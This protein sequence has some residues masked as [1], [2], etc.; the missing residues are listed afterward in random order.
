MP[1]F[2]LDLDSTVNDSQRQNYSRQ[3]VIDEI[4][5]GS[6]QQPVNIEKVE[7]AP[8]PKVLIPEGAL[9]TK[10]EE[11]KAEPKPEIKQDLPK[12][13]NLPSK[14]HSSTISPINHQYSGKAPT[15]D[16]FIPCTDITIVDLIIDESVVK[17]HTSKT[18]TA[19]AKED[20][21]T[22][23]AKTVNYRTALLPSGT[24]FRAINQSRIADTLV[25]GQTVVFTS[26][27][28]LFT[29]YF[30]IP[31][32]T[33]FTARVAD[34]HKPQMTCNGGL[35]GLKIVSANINGYN[36]QLDGSILRLKND[37]IY[38]SNLK[39]EHTYFK[40]VRKKAK[41]G[42]NKFKQWSKTSHQLANK[43][44]GVVL[45]PF[46]YIGGCVL[47]AASTVSSPATA[48]LGKGGNLVIPPKTTFTIKLNSDARLR[49]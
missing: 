16:A 41:W 33:K 43:G 36:Q 17:S 25:E 13:P 21:T 34:A 18:K 10:T 2:A 15:A 20:K 1:S 31:K 39:G 8:A 5:K 3:T 47:A 12:V 49:Y 24:Q 14:V 40:T 30:K 23:T 38:F 6:Q 37:R 45:A 7:T 28:D 32:G 46:P 11:V 19:Q 48:L 22:K 4:Q 44:A 27:Q 26:T 29:S 42:Q 35:V 9:D